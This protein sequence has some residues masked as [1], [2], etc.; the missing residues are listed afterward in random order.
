MKCRIQ[1][2]GLCLSFFFFIGVDDAAF[3]VVAEMDTVDIMIQGDFFDQ[4]LIEGTP[5]QTRARTDI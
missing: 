3:V 4:P 2:A 1:K 5:R